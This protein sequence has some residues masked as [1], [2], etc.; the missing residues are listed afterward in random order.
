MSDGGHTVL[1]VLKGAEQ[2]LSKRGV[3]APR[4]SAEL[5]L[6]KVLALPRLSLYLAHDRPL[7]ESERAA[8]RA[9]LMRRGEG[10][11]VAYLLGSQSFRGHELAV[12]PAVL[13]PRPETEELVSLALERA[14]QGG[15]VLDLGTGSGA[16]AIAIAKERSDLRVVAADVSKNALDLAR[17]NVARHALEGRVELRHGSWW[18]PVAAAEV[19]DLV[20]SNP[21]YIDPDAPTGLAA[22]VKAF[23][24][25]LALF[26]SPGDP[27][28]CYR[29]IAAGLE[30]HL[31]AGC[32]FL[33][34]AGLGSTEP[35]RACLQQQPWLEEVSLVEDLSG[36]DRFVLARR[37]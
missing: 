19:F 5:L 34:E 37:R 17:A 28:S 15:S 27:A 20:V 26:T 16:I 12:S 10:E 31:R 4:L 2:W 35:A 1:S 36:H 9:L 22:D 32:W 18:Q 21:P 11:P 7:D 3:D 24:P 14:P 29:E 30:Q 33:G 13:I 23:E 8:M 25:P 6:G